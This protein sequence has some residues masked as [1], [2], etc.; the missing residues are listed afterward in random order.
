[1]KSV[2]KKSPKERM[3]FSEMIKHSWFEGRVE[4]QLNTKKDYLEIA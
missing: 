2:L 3:S 1:M 4:E